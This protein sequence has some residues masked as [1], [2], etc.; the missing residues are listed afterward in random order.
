MFFT[1]I[2]DEIPNIFAQETVSVARSTFVEEAIST[3]SSGKWYEIAQRDMEWPAKIDGYNLSYLREGDESALFSTDRYSAPL[4]AFGRRGIG[5]TAAIAFPLGGDFSESVR[6]WESYGDFLQTGLRWIIGEQ[7]PSGIGVRHQIDGSEL[8]IDLIYDS[9]I[10]SDRFALSPPRLVI[11][12][13]N[14]TRAAEPLTWERLAPGHYSVK[15]ELR[16]SE[17]VR[18]AVQITGSALPFGPVVAGSALEWEFNRERIIELEESAR[19]SGG[20]ELLD[21]S[22]AWRKPEA[23]GVTPI[24]EW[25]F[26][27]ALLAFLI[28]T[29]AT[30]TGWALPQWTPGRKSAF[31]VRTR[32]SRASSPAPHAE[33]APIAEAKP[34]PEQD[35]ATRKNRYTRAKR[36][37]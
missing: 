32:A 31:P 12:R 26:L 37:H 24:R 25:L 35:T 1:T 36:R 16:E 33:I 11:E 22:Q 21:L 6:S 20:G 17:P 28:E 3:Q 4:V 10:W 34:L 23:S 13:G 9:E 18:G 27:A 30:R 5:R 15:T 14:E 2:P 7:V 8:T 29:F 19:T